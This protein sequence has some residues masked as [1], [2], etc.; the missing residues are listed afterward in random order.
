MRHS[1]DTHREFDL[2]QAVEQTKGYERMEARRRMKHDKQIAAG[3]LMSS[4]GMDEGFDRQVMA[5]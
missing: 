5:R 2:L 4:S 3:V 1:F